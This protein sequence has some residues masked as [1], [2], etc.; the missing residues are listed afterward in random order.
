MGHAGAAHSMLA[1]AILCCNDTHNVPQE[2]TLLGPE[3]LLAILAQRNTQLKHAQA[4][5]AQLQVD[6]KQQQLAAEA[7]L[8]AAHS[9]QQAAV[10]QAAKKQQ[11]YMR[12]VLELEVSRDHTC[13]TAMCPPELHANLTVSH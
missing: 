10:A 7:Q 3:Q 11:E 2:L 1:G 9:Q 8:A 12:Q 13:K 6:I 4:S 5:A